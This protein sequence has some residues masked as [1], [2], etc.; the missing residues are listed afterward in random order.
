LGNYILKTMKRKL[1]TLF[2]LVGIIMTSY[3]QSM[4]KNAVGLRLGDNSGFGGELSYQ[5][6]LSSKNRLEVDFGFRSGAYYNAVK[7]TNVYQWVWKIDGG[8]NWYAGP[9]LG[10][11]SWSYN[12][13]YKYKGNPYYFYDE[14]VN[15]QDRGIYIFAAGN[16]GIEYDFDIPL[17][18][19]LDFRP[20][21]YINGYGDNI[22]ADIGLGIRYQ[23]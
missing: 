9:G 3:S 5:R 16:I 17:M 21:F 12:K 7:I 14:N 10:I 1:L 22:G 20:E 8:F 15:F 11:G 18:L 2:L 4:S 6:K 13:R 23:F 19:S